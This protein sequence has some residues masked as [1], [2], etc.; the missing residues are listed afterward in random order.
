VPQFQQKIPTGSLT[1]DHNYT[2]VQ[3]TKYYD[4]YNWYM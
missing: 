4:A 3:C 1:I 2:F